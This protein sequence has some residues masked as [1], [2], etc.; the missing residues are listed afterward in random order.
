MKLREYFWI[1]SRKKILKATDSVVRMKSSLARLCQILNLLRV[2]SIRVLVHDQR[3]LL[4]NLLLLLV[5]TTVL[6]LLSHHMVKLLLLL[7][8]MMQLLLL[9]HLFVVVREHVTVPLEV[10]VDIVGH[11]MTGISVV[12]TAI[13]VLLKKDIFKKN[14]VFCH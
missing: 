13:I 11:L 5:T 8:K 6:L 12:S 4:E 3:L 14:S 2:V 9:V 10:V 7:L 1:E